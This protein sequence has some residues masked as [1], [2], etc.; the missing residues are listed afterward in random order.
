[1]IYCYKKHLVTQFNIL[2]R[3]HTVCIHFKEELKTSMIIGFL[4]AGLECD[5][6]FM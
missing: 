1:M 4:C 5:T 2:L 6:N 3:V